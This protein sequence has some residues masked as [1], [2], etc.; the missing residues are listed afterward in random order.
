MKKIFSIVALFICLSGFAQEFKARVAMSYS[1]LQNPDRELFNKMRQDI[2]E[3][4]NNRTW[5]KHSFEEVERI[6]ISFNFRIM[7]QSSDNYSASV[8]VQASRP[9]YGATY[10]SPLLN[11]LD[12]NV[13]FQYQEFQSLEFEEN[14]HTSNLTSVIAFYAYFVLGLDYDSFQ[15]NGG[16]EYYQKAQ[17]IVTTAQSASERGW[18][19]YESKTNRYWLA[20]DVLNGTY[21]A[22][23]SCLY[24][25]HRLGLDVMSE[26]P[27]D[28]RAKIEQAINDL[29]KVYK[30]KPGAFLLDFFFYAKKTELKN[31]YS[32]AMPDEQKRVTTILKKINPANA[33]DYDQIGKK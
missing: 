19:S 20:D 33:S 30:V 4:I 9:I 1:E 3:F 25:Y 16:T 18:K 6:E 13:S 26:K 11:Y 31:I 5:T 10:T 29:N 21:S 14:T 12:E 23:R 15:E 2:E 32:D 7:S 28:G 27:K 8:Q 22:F 24:K 17:N